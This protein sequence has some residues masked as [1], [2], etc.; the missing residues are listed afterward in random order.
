M[1]DTATDQEPARQRLG[2]W[3]QN[4]EPAIKQMFEQIAAEQPEL[5]YKVISGGS[6]TPVEGQ[7][8]DQHLAVDYFEALNNIPAVYITAEP[9][10]DPAY[11]DVGTPFKVTWTEQAD[12]A[13][14]G[15][16]STAQ[17]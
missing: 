9:V 17:L 15:H 12:R 2:L 3:W 16:R 8:L 4:V 14:A 6:V 11:P 5:V 1:S 13:P 7:T 10:A